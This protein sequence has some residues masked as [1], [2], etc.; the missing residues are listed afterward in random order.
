MKQKKTAVKVTLRIRMLNTGKESLYL[1]FYPPIIDTETKKESRRESLGMYIHPLKNKNG[2]YIK[3]KNGKYKYKYNSFDIETIRLAETIRGNRQNELDKANIYTD[4]EA[5]ILKAKE[6]SKGDFLR[7]FRQ[8]ADDK[9]EANQENWNSALK[10]LI[11][12]TKK[13]EKKEAI[14]FC[15]ITLQWCEGFKCY[16]LTT[17]SNRSD[18]A[19]LANNTAA[20]YFVKLKVALKTAYKYGYLSKD[21][22]ADLKSIKE[23][24]T[25]REFLTLEELR[26]LVETPCNDEVMKRAA[27]FS[28]LT[29]LR[30]SDILKMKWGEIIDTNGKYTLRYTIQKTQKYDELPIS[31]DAILLCGERQEPEALVFAGLKY[32]AYVNKALAQWIGAA[33]VTRNITFHI[34]RHRILPFRLRMSKLQEAFS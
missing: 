28:A 21:I 1:D 5:E 18:K 15:D 14:R 3:G 25:K 7:F 16:L 34:A 32:S 26:K 8:L 33:G 4:T 17:N 11:I 22:N 12:Y 31:G 13:T 29:G 10:H 9:R 23:V 19:K 20:A 6:R 24:E 27:L 30:H 2:E